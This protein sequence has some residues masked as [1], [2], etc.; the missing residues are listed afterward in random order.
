MRYESRPRGAQ[1]CPRYSRSAPGQCSANHTLYLASRT[2][3]IAHLQFIPAWQ[4]CGSR[5]PMCSFSTATLIKLRIESS[6]TLSAI[7]AA[8][9]HHRRVDDYLA[10]A[11]ADF[12][13]QPTL[14][15]TDHSCSSEVVL[16][17]IDRFKYVQ[18]YNRL[19]TSNNTAR[20]PRCMMRY[21]CPTLSRW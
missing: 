16:L 10:H 20:L 18:Y 15:C 21:V 19:D 2:A 9:L 17:Q 5:Q 12:L 8:Y 1:S 11:H 4:E 13:F 6:S 7:E 14:I 3:R